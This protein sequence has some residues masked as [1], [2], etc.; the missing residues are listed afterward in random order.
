MCAYGSGREELAKGN[1]GYTK[2]LTRW[3]PRQKRDLLSH[4]RSMQ[5]H[6]RFRS[7]SS[8]FFCM[9][10]RAKMHTWCKCVGRLFLSL[11]VVFFS[12]LYKRTG[13]R[14]CGKPAGEVPEKDTLLGDVFCFLYLISLIHFITNAWC[15][16]ALIARC[17]FLW[18][19]HA[20]LYDC[21][22]T[23]TG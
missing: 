1:A 3:W 11:P 20:S 21:T 9:R 2:D 12:S 14:K 22:S 4:T 7:L 17:A 16:A 18:R 5:N 15:I 8:R 23:L 13:A 10:W 6:L 19:E